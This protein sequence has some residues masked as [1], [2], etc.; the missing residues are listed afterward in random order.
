M[1]GKWTWKQEMA[2]ERVG[3]SQKQTQV[4]GEG[5]R[6]ARDSAGTR[7]GLDMGWPNSPELGSEWQ[8]ASGE[9]L[10]LGGGWLAAEHWWVMGLV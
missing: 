6:K 8:Q 3:E 4:R 5:S 7:V 1:F 2:L 10:S 9:P